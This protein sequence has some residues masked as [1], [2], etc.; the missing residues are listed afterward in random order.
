MKKV[1]KISAYF[2][3]TLLFLFMFLHAGAREA[4]A[5]VDRIV[6]DMTH[7]LPAFGPMWDSLTQP[8]LNKPVKGSKPI[9][10]Y[11]KQMVLINKPNFPTS[12]GYFYWNIFI[13]EE[14]HGTHLDVPGHYVNNEKTRESASPDLRTAEELTSKDLMGP[15]VL[16]DISARVE[17]ELAKNGGKPS[18][19]T[20][21]TDFSDASGNAVTPADID[22][23]ADQL[24]D[25][26]WLIMHS[27]WGKFFAGYD[28]G[29][30]GPYLN[31]FN[32]PGFTRKAVDRIIEIEDQKKIRIN[33]LGADQV[34]ID[35]GINTGLPKFVDAYPA[36]VRG[37]QRGWKMLENLANTDMLAQM[38]PGKCSLVVGA[39]KHTGGSGGAARIFAVCEKE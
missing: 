17:K 10:S 29:H 12:D 16:V 38:K 1:L 3:F 2:C 34:Q 33:G 19:D 31:G 18:T 9:A 14:H 28:P 32:F 6:I 4:D 21:V 27:G 20:A 22:A 7:A 24:T 15:V 37:L 5:W 23:V 25:G 30:G 13:L 11:G 8:D 39:L 36:H 26:A 35:T